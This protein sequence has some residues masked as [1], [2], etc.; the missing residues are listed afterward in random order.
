MKRSNA[1]PSR[2]LKAE[3]LD[4]DEDLKL[5][6][7][8][9]R[10]EDLQDPKT[11]ENVPKP[12]VYWREDRKPLVLNETNWNSIEK[13]LGSVESDDWTGQVIALYVTEVEAFGKRVDAIRVRTK[14]QRTPSGKGDGEI[15]NDDPVE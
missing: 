8:D 6:I 15:V 14:R 2:W 7:K 1:F 9:V 12:V 4:R 11:G 13:L 10:M 3:D 5:T